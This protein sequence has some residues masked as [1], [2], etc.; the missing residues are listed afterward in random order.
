[1]F[2]LISNDHIEPEPVI[3]AV[4]IGTVGCKILSRSLSRSVDTVKGIFIHS[5]KNFL[6]NLGVEKANTMLLSSDKATSRINTPRDAFLAIKDREAELE[7]LLNNSDIVFVV[8]GLGG[9]TGS[10]CS[11]YIAEYVRRQDA[12]CLGMFSLPFEFEGRGKKGAALKA[13]S[14]LINNT[15][16]LLLIENEV[17]L[18]SESQ[19]KVKPLYSNLFHESNIYF[20]ALITGLSS[21]V[22]RSGLLNVSYKDL[23]IV[24]KSMGP[25]AVGF[26]S[27][28]RGNRATDSVLQAINAAEYNGVDISSAKGCL[29]SITTGPDFSIDEFKEFANAVKEVFSEN[30]IVVVGTV[31]N[32]EMIDQIEVTLILSGL[33]GPF[34]D[35]SAAKE[36]FFTEVVRTIVFEPHQASSGIA[37]L[38]YFGEVIKQKHADIQASVSIEQTESSVV[39]I[40][41]TPN[42]EVE[43]IEKTLKE[44]GEVILGKKT[45]AEFLPNKIDAQRLEFKLEM[46]SME[47]R[48][49]EKLLLIYQDQNSEYKG[50][51]DSLEQQVHNL[52]KALS[53]GL[54]SSNRN[55]KSI[56]SK[57]EQIPSNL[58]KLLEAHNK[59]ELSQDTIENIELKIRKLYAEDR[60]GFF[61][62]SDLIKNGV[63][64]VAGNGMY[65][66]L[67]NLVQT[68]PK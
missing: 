18:N 29:V 17:F 2:E 39:L 41:E 60:A 7:K 55:L 62:L 23:R 40:I 57:H 56:I 50:R 25:C 52:Q 31:I 59:S 8:A 22:T 6:A 68:L 35:M 30:I 11:P 13:Y 54:T 26:G 33:K 53:S 9:A 46:T 27:S 19:S 3:V 21:L 61:S 28:N 44:Y 1:M 45:P 16:S 37:I 47:L 67:I 32:M 64:G 58:L 12:L 48:Q 24:L 20:F 15:D 34:I 49:N 65:N 51:L 36:G 14:E 43:K 42:G 10:G 63:Y 4:G 38:S 5:N 66:F